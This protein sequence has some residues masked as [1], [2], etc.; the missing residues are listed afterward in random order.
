MKVPLFILPLLLFLFVF[1]SCEK[2]IDIDL[3]D[4]S[5]KIVIEGLITD[6][7]SVDSFTVKVSRS[8]NFNSEG[9]NL[10]IDD[11]LVIMEDVSMGIKDTLTL[12]Q[13]GT[14]KS[15]KIRGSIGHLYQLEVRIAGVSY[16]A[17]SKMPDLVPLD[18]LYEQKI[19]A[20]ADAFRQIIPVFTDPVGVQNFYTF[21]LKVNDSSQTEFQPWDDRLSDGKTNSRPLIIGDAELFDGQDTVFV[22]MNCTD[23][24]IFDFFNTLENAS[25]NGQT[26]ANP[27]SMFTNGAIGYFGAVTTRTRSLIIP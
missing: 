8:N 6:D 1:S 21:S 25:G 23:K 3:K 24:G 5:P 18:S 12:T 9:K 4:S 7:P 17:S 16:T 19:P 14:Y 20:F 27:T 22:T 26:P 13:A 10:P 15:S 2:V 11:A